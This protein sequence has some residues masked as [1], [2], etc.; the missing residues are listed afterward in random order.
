[1]HGEQRLEADK[2]KDNLCF[3]LTLFKIIDIHDTLI[4]FVQPEFHFREIASR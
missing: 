2:Y 3:C 1:M 4:C